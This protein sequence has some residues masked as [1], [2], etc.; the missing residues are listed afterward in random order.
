MI[1]SDSKILVLSKRCFDSLPPLY[2]T[3]A[4]EGEAA[5][6]VKIKDDT[7]SGKVGV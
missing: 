3:V 5:G 1:S 2:Q 7:G 6:L 4:R